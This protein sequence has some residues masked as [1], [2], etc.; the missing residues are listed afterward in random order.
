M[1]VFQQTAI[2]FFLCLVLVAC[3]KDE[4]SQEAVAHKANTKTVKMAEIQP[5][6]ANLSSTPKID[7]AYLSC[8][9]PDSLQFATLPKF[10]TMTGNTSHFGKLDNGISILTLRECSFD[11]EKRTVGIVMDM[12]LRNKDGEG[13]RFLGSVNMSMEGPTSGIFEVIEGY[14]KFKGFTGWIDTEG[15]LNTELG[16]IFL[17]V[18]GMITQPYNRSH[19]YFAKNK[20]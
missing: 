15:F 2:A 18:D 6:K 5:F 17:S 8:L 14:G 3:K 13:L 4:N 10:S 19:G 16:T 9:F 7:S 12:M 11:T 20:P 1:Q